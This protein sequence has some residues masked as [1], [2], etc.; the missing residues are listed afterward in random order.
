[1]KRVSVFIF[2]VVLAL[3]CQSTTQSFFSTNITGD[4]LREEILRD[5]TIL[6]PKSKTGRFKQLVDQLTRVGGIS[7]GVT[8]E[9][10]VTKLV[11]KPNWRRKMYLKGLGYLSN[12]TMNKMVC[13]LLPL[14]GNDNWPERLYSYTFI[15]ARRN[16]SPELVKKYKKE[17]VE[18]VE[19]FV[20]ED[21]T[22][23]NVKLGP[24][25]ERV[26]REALPEK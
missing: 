11:G 12:E 20:Q 2:F 17:L 14:M 18:R 9:E 15:V 26:I 24:E 1:M 19:R 13:T 8:K 22:L 5:I 6:H 3:S 4:L 25:I 10:L 21:N 16:H 23:D 7:K